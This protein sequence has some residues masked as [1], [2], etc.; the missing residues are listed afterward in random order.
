[1]CCTIELIIEFLS[2]LSNVNLFTSKNLLT[3]GSPNKDGM[4]ELM[5]AWM[6]G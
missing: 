6:D 3:G 1:M 4:N 5:D 2:L